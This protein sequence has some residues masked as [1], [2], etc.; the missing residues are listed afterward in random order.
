VPG[1]DVSLH[2]AERFG[3][4]G[5]RPSHGEK[6]IPFA[7]PFTFHFANGCAG[8]RG[9]RQGS[10]PLEVLVTSTRIVPALKSL[11]RLETITGR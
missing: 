6:R 5:R 2:Q 7:D 1:I 3:Y 11:N 10:F 4:Q 9:G 8:G